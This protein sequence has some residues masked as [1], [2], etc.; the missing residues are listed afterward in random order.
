[1]GYEKDTLL[2]V[3]HREPMI[4]EN[5]CWLLKLL[6]LEP[7]SETSRK[8]GLQPLACKSKPLLKEV[9]CC[10]T[11][12][13]EGGTVNYSPLLISKGFLF[14]SRVKTNFS[15]RRRNNE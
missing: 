14:S 2:R 7:T 15:F 4:A 5:G 12:T 8:Y 9:V 6:T 10:E 1:M 11:T 3:K 13:K